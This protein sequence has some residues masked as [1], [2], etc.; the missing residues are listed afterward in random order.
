[1]VMQEQK[2]LVVQLQ[3]P[4]STG[5]CSHL[6]KSPQPLHIGDRFAPA[7]S[8]EPGSTPTRKLAAVGSGDD[9]FTGRRLGYEVLEWV[10]GSSRIS[11]SAP[12]GNIP[13]YPSGRPFVAV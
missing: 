10:L 11:I 3:A 8:H 1:M 9:V 7:H 6:S 13:V 5:S 4:G 2:V 12:A